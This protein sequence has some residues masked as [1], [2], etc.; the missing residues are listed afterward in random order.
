M[1]MAD[2]NRHACSLQELV[3]EGFSSEFSAVTLS[4][5]VAM[6]A[7]SPWWL[8]AAP[9]VAGGLGLSGLVLLGIALIMRRRLA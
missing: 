7:P 3:L 1:G 8:G 6:H 4:V 5:P 9:F 2:P